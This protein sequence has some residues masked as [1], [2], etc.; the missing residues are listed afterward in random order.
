MH[1]ILNDL[2]KKVAAGCVF[3]PRP[4]SGVRPAARALI[5][6]IDA[7]VFKWRLALKFR[8]RVL[9]YQTVRTHTERARPLIIWCLFALS[10]STRVLHQGI[11]PMHKRRARRQTATTESMRR[12][13]LSL[14][15]PEIAGGA[16]RIAC[17]QPICH[18]HVCV[19]ILC[20]L[21]N[22]G[23]SEMME[24]CAFMR[25]AFSL[26][27]LFGVDKWFINGEVKS[28]THSL[29]FE[30]IKSDRQTDRLQSEHVC[31]ILRWQ[32]MKL[33]KN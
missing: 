24:W 32:Q 1:G 14:I 5:I 6:I 29:H 13:I 8:T 25:A 33:L 10:S 30:S 18:M 7:F 11:V 20:A 31:S 19:C 16:A 21:R 28:C 2:I 9:R 22:N 3:F 12:S 15:T 17:S 26:S 4:Y 27:F 23:D